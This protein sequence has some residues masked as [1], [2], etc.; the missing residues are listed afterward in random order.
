MFASSSNQSN[1]RILNLPRDTQEILISLA[2]SFLP[3]SSVSIVFVSI[4]LLLLF[5]DY[6]TKTSNTYRLVKKNGQY[7]K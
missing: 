6:F 1:G 7:A 2:R 5:W 3:F 4:K